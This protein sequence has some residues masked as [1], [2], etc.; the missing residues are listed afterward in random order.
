MRLQLKNLKLANGK[1]VK[2]EYNRILEELADQ[3]EAMEFRESYPNG[4]HQNVKEWR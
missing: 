2:L 1:S 4:I 3:F